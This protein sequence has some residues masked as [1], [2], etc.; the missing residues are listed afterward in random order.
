MNRFFA[1]KFYTAKIVFE[2]IFVWP[3]GLKKNKNLE[4]HPHINTSS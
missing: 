2:N 3:Y 4:A 1:R